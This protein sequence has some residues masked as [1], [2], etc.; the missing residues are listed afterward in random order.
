MNGENPSRPVVHVQS[1]TLAVGTAAAGAQS[2][3]VNVQGYAV[4]VITSVTANTVNGRAI[5]AYYANPNDP[6]LNIAHKA[7][8]IPWEVAP[9][10]LPSCPY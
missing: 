6:A 1:L 7:G 8:L 10:G 2:K 3:Y 9:C 5:S 4:F